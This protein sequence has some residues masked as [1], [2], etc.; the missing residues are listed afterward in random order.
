MKLKKKI[1]KNLKDSYTV[2]LG[3]GLM[4]KPKMAGVAI[5]ARSVGLF[6]DLMNDSNKKMK[7]KRW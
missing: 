5:G 1:S 6:N 3:M 2:G 4:G 7:K